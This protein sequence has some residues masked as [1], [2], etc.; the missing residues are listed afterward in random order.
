MGIFDVKNTRMKSEKVFTTY[1]SHF[2]FVKMLIKMWCTLTNVQ[3]VVKC[4]FFT[5]DTSSSLKRAIEYVIDALHCQLNASS[6]LHL[7]RD[8][9]L[10]HMCKEKE[11]SDPADQ[12]HCFN[13]LCKQKALHVIAL[14]DIK[15]TELEAVIHLYRNRIKVIVLK[16]PLFP[17]S[18]YSFI[19]H[20]WRGPRF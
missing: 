5:R 10:P 20:V 9:S 12:V 15:L 2:P 18:L 11:L 7:I 1:S 8:R 16:F 3:F 6:H 4:N 13:N 19:R 14:R 17:D